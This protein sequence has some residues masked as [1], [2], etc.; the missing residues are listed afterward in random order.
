MARAAIQS[1]VAGVAG[2]MDDPVGTAVTAKTNTAT[3]LTALDT[4]MADLVTAIGT[5]TYSATTHQFSGTLASNATVTVANGNAAIA[6]L[7]TALTDVL[8]IRTALANQASADVVI[9]FDAA[10]V[11]GNLRTLVNQMMGFAGAAA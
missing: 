9:S 7:N 1:T 10:K 2:A 4:A 3:A 8:A 5:V 11:I 6:A